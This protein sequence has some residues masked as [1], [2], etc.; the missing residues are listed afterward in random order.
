MLGTAAAG[1]IAA[2]CGVNSNEGAGTQPATTAT[3]GPTPTT[4]STSTTSTTTTTTTTSG[5]PATTTTVA[6]QAATAIDVICKEAWGAQPVGGDFRD[7]QIAQITVHHTAIRL[8]D[9]K[10]APA[11]ARRH[12]AYHQSL[13]WPDLAYHYLID[14]AGNVYEGRPVSAAGDTA[15]DYDPT[16]HLL[17]CCE[18]DFD[19]QEVPT[20]Q[21]ESLVAMLAWGAAEFGVDPQT[22]RGH[23]DV[24]STTCPGDALYAPLADGTL[25][26]RVAD[27]MRLG[28]LQLELICGSEGSAR[29]ETIEAGTG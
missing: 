4:G 12:Q 21:Y 7:H 28:A 18:G 23:R 29:I 25:H 9:N 13:G 3:T 5:A 8:E 10:D 24:A 16:G 14:A 22:I 11:Q 6:P 15:T 20:A 2:A 17:I 26:A 1:L 19:R 27:A